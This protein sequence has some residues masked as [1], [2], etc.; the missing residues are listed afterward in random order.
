MNAPSHPPPVLLRFGVFEADPESRELRK[1][2]MHIRLP[3]QA[4]Q[5]L[6]I[7][8]EN[9]G[10]LVPREELHKRL[11]PADTFVEFDHNLNNSISRLREALSDSAESPRFIETLPRRGYRFIAS[12]ES[13]TGLSEAASSTEVSAPAPVRR[14]GWLVAFGVTMAVAVTA[15]FGYRAL[16]PASHPID[17]VAVLPFVTA[18][19]EDG[20]PDDY[21]A[22]G[23][24]EALISEL[25][26]RGN[27]KVVSQTSVLR[28]KDARKPLPEIA[29]ELGVGAVVEG[30]VVH[31]G[32][33]IRI[34]VQLIAAASD[35][36]IWAETYRR[37]A[38]SI[39]SVQGDLAQSIGREI[40]VR[41]TGEPGM[42]S[43]LTRPTVPQAQEA[44]LKGRYFLS[45]RGE[46]NMD[47]ARD[48]FLQAIAADPQHAQA[49]AGLADY[50][51]LTDSMQPAAAI[52]KAREYALKALELNSSL[53]DAHVSLAYVH[54]YGDWNWQ[55][56]E[57]AF[58]RAI[59]LDPNHSQAH[60]WYGRFLGT[61]GR[62][63]EARNQMQL[64]LAVD[65]LS[66][67]V[68]DAAA[69]EG[70]Y[71]RQFDSMIEQANRIRE[72]NPEDY[73]TF[74]H[75]TVAYLHT[76]HYEQALASARQGLA[77]LPREPLFVLFLT[78]VHHKRGRA[79]ESEEA[80]ND[81]ERMGREGYVPHVFL[82]IAYA[83]LG[84]KEKAL[85]LLEVGYRNHDP[86]MVMIKALPWFDPIRFEPR[87]QELLR[88]MKFP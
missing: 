28:Y 2:G 32:N 17:S 45:R 8:L 18:S 20:S 67:T 5:V 50:F 76:G 11:W 42:P 79:H 73:R 13:P 30:S 70:F 78:I 87:F 29:R 83:Q 26:R 64:A 88:K 56:C 84:R 46:E 85:A 77:L 4:F 59:A 60:Y 23:M 24:T 47:R 15:F 53:A 75:L 72:L 10:R 48:Y 54:Y 63:T 86:Y 12:V 69:M 36:H 68:H 51:T 71:S 43:R 22:F 9:A 6:L 3:D 34:T 44:Y 31:E 25:S 27:L 61:M 33:Q 58:Q 82:A 16:S 39:M 57:M 65:P 19:S 7:L 38:A 14:A 55:A 49:F 52:A 35:S 80:L 1:Q 66:N 41:L 37:E 40:G 62:H 81:L 21:V 74:E